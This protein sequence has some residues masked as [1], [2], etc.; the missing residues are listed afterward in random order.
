MEDTKI[1]FERKPYIK[2]GIIMETTLEIVAGTEVPV[3]KPGS[4]GW[5]DPNQTFYP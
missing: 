3:P 1:Q 4:D 5:I 2:P